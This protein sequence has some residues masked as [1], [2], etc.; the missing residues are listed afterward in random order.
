MC[1]GW[2]GGGGGGE[3][4]LPLFLLFVSNGFLMGGRKGNE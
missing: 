2:G 1:I 4:M 3:N